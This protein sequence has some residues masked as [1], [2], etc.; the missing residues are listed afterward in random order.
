MYNLKWCTKSY[1]QLHAYRLK[2]NKSAKV[3]HQLDM[4]GNFIIKKA[5][6]APV[7]LLDDLFAKIDSN[8]IEKMLSE[9]LKNFQ[10]FIT[11]TDI[12]KDGV[13]TWITPDTK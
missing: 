8:K 11:S 9:M 7:L 2:L 13:K 5:S 1:N 6:I 10:T 3:V 4:D 12:H